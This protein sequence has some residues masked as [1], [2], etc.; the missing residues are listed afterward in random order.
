MAI[1]QIDT[2]DHA[3]L[4]CTHQ[5]LIF[6]NA[7]LEARYPGGH[8]AFIDQFG[9][10]TNADISVHCVSAA[11]IAPTVGKFEAMGLKRSRDFV[12]IDAVECEMW[13]MIH[14]DAIKRP[15]WFDTGAD[16]LRY[17]H[18]KGRMLVWYAH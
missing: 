2:K 14:A 18:W 12:V 5:T 6:R 4:V 9:A 15:F 11:V 10:D 8:A 16:W 3:A 7:S 1:T 13:R 17:R